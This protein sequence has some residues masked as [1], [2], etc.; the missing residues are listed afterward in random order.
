MKKIAVIT[1]ASSGLGTQFART[2][3]EAG[4]AVVL[5]GTSL[6]G[7]RGSI[8]GTV[9]GALTISIIGNGLIL[10]HVSPFFTQIVTGIIILAAIWMNTR[11]FGSGFKLRKG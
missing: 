6:M 2:L 1:G 9:L 5:G 10:M 8:L 11:L 7:G 4:A 3:A